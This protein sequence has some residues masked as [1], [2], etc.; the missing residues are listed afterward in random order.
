MQCIKE[1]KDTQISFRINSGQLEKLK[2]IAKEF[3]LPYQSYLTL[4]I[5]NHIKEE[6]K[7]IL[8]KEEK[9]IENDFLIGALIPPSEEKK[10]KLLNKIKENCL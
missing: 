7:F 1:K 3:G 4:V 8:T 10:Q 9:E 6:W 5:N 2:I